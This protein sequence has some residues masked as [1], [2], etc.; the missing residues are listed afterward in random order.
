MRGDRDVVRASAVDDR[1]P[2][3]EGDGLR[4]SEIGAADPTVPPRVI[5]HV[6]QGI[7]DL[8]GRGVD[9]SGRP[10]THRE[11][12]NRRPR[13]GSCNVSVPSDK[14][15]PD[16]MLEMNVWLEAHEA[17]DPWHG[18]QPRYERLVKVAPGR[19]GLVAKLPSGK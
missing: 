8:L 11:I 10:D 6:G 7:E 12:I 17:G 13:G 16:T 2:R 4:A 19:L 14:R 3:S 1:K 18:R 9:P 15:R 5:P